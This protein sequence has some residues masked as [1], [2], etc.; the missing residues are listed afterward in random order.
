MDEPGPSTTFRLL[1]DSDATRLGRAAYFLYGLIALAAFL[2]SIVAVS[3]ILEM[4]APRTRI[5][6]FSELV[7]G[8][9]IVSIAVSVLGIALIGFFLRFFGRFLRS[10]IV[11]LTVTPS[12]LMLRARGGTERKVLWSSPHLRLELEVYSPA[13]ATPNESGF[14][15]GR[16]R[17]RG[18]YR[19]GVCQVD[20]RV[21][22][23]V[24]DS[25]TR[26]KVRVFHQ[27]RRS[28]EGPVVRLSFRRAAAN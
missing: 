24:M 21:L 7:L 18:G 20:D 9:P 16:V 13:P 14:H 6:T 12:G 22:E 1:S 19:G 15:W 11:G 10:P 3:A 26:R 4:F 25:A 23:T 28:L 8:Y 2:P 5:P 27:S 17:F